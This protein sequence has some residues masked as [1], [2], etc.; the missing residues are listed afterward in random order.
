MLGIGHDV[1]RAR[2]GDD[3]PRARGQLARER[4]INVINDPFE[5][6]VEMIVKY[7]GNAL[8]KSLLYINN[9]PDDVHAAMEG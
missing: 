2:D 9:R 5:T 4:S 6:G 7:A 8:D 1:D 3:S